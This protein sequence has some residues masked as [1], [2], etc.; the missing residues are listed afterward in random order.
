MKLNRLRPHLLAT[1]LLTAAA[2]A[3]PAFAEDASTVQAVVVTGS[4]IPQPNLTSDSPLQTV[5]QAD[6]K[7]EGTTTV[8][9]LLNEMP[10]VAGGQNLGQSINSTGTATVNLRNL[11]AQR[12]LVLVDGRR[13]PPGDAAT[14]VA[15][16]NN[17]PAA[18]VDRIDLVTG[19]ASAVYGADAV[20]GVVNFIMK[21]N[22]QGVQLD[23]QASA[24]QHS[25]NIGAD[26]TILQ[27]TNIAVPGNKFD[28]QQYTAS[29][30]LGLNAPDDKGNI[31]VFGSYFNSQP[32]LQS[33]RDYSACGIETISSTTANIYDTHMC[34][35][36]SNSAYG[37]FLPTPNIVNG[38]HLTNPAMTAKGGSIT[39]HDNPN[40][41]PTFVTTGVP[42]YNFNNQSYLQRED[43]RY[44]FGYFAHYEVNKHVDVYS[45]LM[46]MDDRTQAQYAPSGFFGGSGPVPHVPTFQINCNNPFL[47]SNGTP[48]QQGVDLCG[49]AAGTNVN[50]L[51]QIG[52]RFTSA[53]R[54]GDFRHDTFKVDLG[55][56]GE[57]DDAWSYDAYIQLGKSAYTQYA[58][59]YSSLNNLQN[60]LLVTTDP[61][62]GAPVCI[63]GGSCVP[64]NI[65]TAKSSSITPAAFAYVLVPGIMQGT[66]EEDI[67]SASVNGDLG[68]YGVKSPWASDSVKVALGTEYRRENLVFSP[69]QEEAS[70]DLSGGGAEPATAGAF[71]VSELFGEAVIP[72]I[73][74]KP[75]VKSMEINPG[76][77]YSDYTSVGTTETYKID[78]SYQPQEDI[79]LRYSYNRAVRAPNIAELYTPQ[80]LS[81]FSGQDPCS[82]AKPGTTLAQ[83]EL[84]GV[85]A[86][87]YGTIQPCPA[88][89]CSTLAGGNPK[90]QPETA[91]TYTY[92]FVLTPHQIPRLSLSVDYYN[93]RI[94]NLISGGYGGA[95]ATVSGCLA[96]NTFLCQQ[97]HRDPSSG[98]LYGAGYVNVVNVNTGFEQTK[99]IDVSAAYSL[100]VQNWG[101]FDIKSTGTYTSH[102]VIEPNAA[103]P[104]IGLAGSGTY[105]CAGLYGAICGQPTPYWRSATRLTW[106][107]PWKVS[108]SLN[109]RFVGSTKVDI[110][111]GNSLVNSQTGYTDTIDAKTGA[112]SYFDLSFSW[113]VKQGY[114]L[115][116]GVNNILD[117][118]PPHGDSTNLGVY[119]ANGGAYG[120]S[121]NGNTYP[122]LYDSLGRNLFI[123][124]TANY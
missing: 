79:R 15:D 104:A 106:T 84:T 20:A 2:I 48:T 114:V 69:D 38:V 70:G 116:G 111:E 120:T 24:N 109:W 71:Q 96:G 18:L 66:T 61:K 49:T 44:N 86:N 103:N 101:R 117:T 52:Y 37:K 118:N 55:A 119:G 54:N 95:N 60:A 10:Q 59:G 78:F 102:F 80:T 68:K 17:V 12:T 35:G 100:T 53:D 65:F 47:M 113:K 90:L 33:A 122:G 83:C 75:W 25:N 64:L 1:T 107:T 16:I 57:L 3:A 77:R 82:G 99:G 36:S 14:P 28:G 9:N 56:R 85:T 74:D 50:A 112:V 43:T 45:D 81:L 73:Q 72:L 91:D 11:G 41:S 88:A 40:G 63:S 19:G 23:A 7:A 29:I 76:Y 6:L 115:R 89:Q 13:L 32:V 42:S 124:I 93:I 8:E 98:E 97:I 121:G 92:G 87:Q 30:L 58:T 5:G 27:N 21:H 108:A 34:A 39:Y 67:A 46:F 51:A 105:D 22:F 94:S 31:T 4:R 110:N 123:G 26:D 62:T